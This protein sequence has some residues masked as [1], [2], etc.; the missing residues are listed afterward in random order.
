MDTD[1]HNLE[2]FVEMFQS[3]IDSVNAK[4]KESNDIEF[5]EDVVLKLFNTL[6]SYA[7][8]FKN[9]QWKIYSQ[10]FTVGGRIGSLGSNEG[11]FAG[12]TDM[13][14]E[15]EIGELFIIDLKTSTIDR[16]N[17]KTYNEEGTVEDKYNYAENDKIQLNTYAYLTEQLAPNA[18]IQGL[19]ILPIQI[20]A[21]E[22]S[23]NSKYTDANNMSGFNEDM[24]LLEVEYEKGAFHDVLGVKPEALVVKKTSTFKKGGGKF[25]TKNVS[26]EDDNFTEKI[27]ELEE[28]KFELAGFLDEFETTSKPVT[29]TSVKKENTFNVLDTFGDEVIEDFDFSENSNAF[30]S[31]FVELDGQKYYFNTK[32]VRSS[33]FYIAKKQIKVMILIL[34]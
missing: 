26:K 6:N 16:S 21:D 25:D 28:G 22:K 13:I 14:A 19:F 15:N 5:S 18:N 9:K 29:K 30:T 2:K 31:N 12:T 4:F 7:E 10:G 1:M 3:N 33:R 34:I 24:P 20:K 17:L 11:R 8:Y 23:T 32:G 27:E